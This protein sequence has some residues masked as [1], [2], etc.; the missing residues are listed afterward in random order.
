MFLTVWV[1]IILIFLFLS[2]FRSVHL[3][4]SCISLHQNHLFSRTLSEQL[5]NYNEIFFFNIVSQKHSL[6]LL[7]CP[8]R[9]ISSISNYQHLTL[10]EIRVRQKL[11]YFSDDSALTVIRLRLA[12]SF[13][14]LL[15]TALQT[16]IARKHVL[17]KNALPARM[18]HGR[19]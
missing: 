7:N 10:N 6:A 15:V 14:V 2:G 8:L 5:W 12:S 9:R 4:R 16:H 18:E 13:P 19:V 17:Q 1:I 11:L 3:F